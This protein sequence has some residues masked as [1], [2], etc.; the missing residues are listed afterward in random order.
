MQ[1]QQKANAR[2]ED[3]ML[4][5]LQPSAGSIEE[6]FEQAFEAA[7]HVSG[8]EHIRITRLRHDTH[9][10]IDALYSKQQ[11]PYEAGQEI[12]IEQLLDQEVIR[13]HDALAI[14]DLSQSPFSRH[15]EVLRT[16]IRSMIG[17]PLWLSNKQIY[18]V[19]SV[20]DHAPQSWGTE[21]LLRTSMIGRWL[22][23]EIELRKMNRELTT[24]S[25]RLSSM[26]QELQ[27]LQKQVEQGSINDPITDLLNSRYFN[28]LM[29]VETAR[30]QRHVYPLSLLLL[31][32]D[33]FAQLRQQFGAAFGDS[34]L[35]SIGVLLRR[36]LRNIDSAARYSDEMFAILLPQTDIS[37]SA[38]VANRIRTTIN[39]HTFVTP[40]SPKVHLSISLG[41]STMN[42]KDEDPATGMS[43]RARRALE[44]ARKAGGNRV[45]VASSSKTS[46]HS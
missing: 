27:R 40:S 19:L 26:A 5:L 28:N 32:P 37:G 34:I 39:T 15:P 25:N 23:H 18:G 24:K 36:H 2:T 46:P 16:H 14:P 10:R 42:N 9:L 38:I 4:N 33:N 44:Q 41:I 11:L 45:I 7:I 12:P 20:F 31:S 17:V 22:A 8:L 13:R 30:A 35:R 21:V 29:R 6:V 3:W 43:S 1:E